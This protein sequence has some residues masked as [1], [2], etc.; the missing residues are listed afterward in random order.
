M[1]NYFIEPGENVIN[2]KRF[3]FNDKTKL[4]LTQMKGTNANRYKLTSSK[5]LK[6]VCLYLNLYLKKINIIQL[7]FNQ[8]LGGD[9]LIL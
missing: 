9:L 6:L 5:R 1:V 3:T 2:F 4:S 8:Y 7:R